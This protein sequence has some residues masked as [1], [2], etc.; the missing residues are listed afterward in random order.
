MNSRHA[1]G[2]TQ[3]DTKWTQNETDFIA[4]K[5]FPALVGNMTFTCTPADAVR[6]DK[7]FCR[8]GLTVIKNGLVAVSV[9]AD[10]R[11][12]EAWLRLNRN[13]EPEHTLRLLAG[14]N[15]EDRKKLLDELPVMAE[16]HEAAAKKIAYA[17]AII[18]AAKKDLL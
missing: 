4:A 14:L 18:D 11:L 7:M 13:T 3:M 5:G 6:P 9:E 15:I 10:Q 17:E 1:M 2:E 8:I 12:Y 16:K